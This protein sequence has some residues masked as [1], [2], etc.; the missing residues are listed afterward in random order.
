MITYKN[1]IIISIIAIIITII[2]LIIIYCCTPFSTTKNNE[3]IIYKNIDIYHLSDFISK[4]HSYMKLNNMATKFITDKKLELFL[5]NEVNK[6]TKKSFQIADRGVW[7]RYYCPG[8][9]NPFE[10]YHYDRQRYAKKSDQIRIVLV[11][12]D[13][14]DSYFCYKERSNNNNIVKIK[15]KPGNITLIYANKLLHAATVKNGERLVLMMD[16]VDDLKRG[17]SG[18]FFIAWDYIWLNILVKYFIGNVN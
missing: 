9:K 5:L 15:S 7:L 6:Y 11:L 3:G 10:N 14:S 12:Y 4:M 18:N 8:V 2:I 1:L 13:N 17:L 16:V